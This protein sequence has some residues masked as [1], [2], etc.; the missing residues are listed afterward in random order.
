MYEVVKTIKGHDILKMKGTKGAYHV[1]IREGKDFKEFH[2][3]KTIKEA[4]RF[5]EAVL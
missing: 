5:I 1:N 4:A 2:T 3:F